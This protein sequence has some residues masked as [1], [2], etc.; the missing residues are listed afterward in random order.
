MTRTPPSPPEVVA[1][2]AAADPPDEA[3]LTAVASLPAMGPF[4]LLALFRG[5]GAKGAWRQVTSGRLPAVPALEGRLG[6]DPAALVRRW[7]HAAGRLDVAELWAAHLAAGVRTAALGSPQYPAALAEDPEPPAVVFMRGDP[8]VLD[9]RRVAVVGTRNCTRVG[10]E[11]AA[12][13]GHGLAAV[14]VRVV[15]GL[16]LGVDGAAHTGALEAALEHPCA[17]PP[18]AVVAGGLDVVYPRR[19]ADLYRRVEQA[20]LVV[21]EAPLGTAPEPWRFPARNR[22]IA[23]L[24]EAVVVVESRLR[25]GSMHTADEALARGI[26]LLAVPGSIRS[27]ASAG[28]N[29]LLA[30]GAM[31]ACDVDD[32]LTAVGLGGVRR[33]TPA[34]SAAWSTRSPA[35]PNDPVEQAVLEALGWEPLTF[36]QLVFR[37]GLGLA[38]LAERVASLESQGFL[39][40][41]DGWLER[42]EGRRV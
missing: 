6:R 16:A 7:A 22:V 4:R 37:T 13:F 35:R 27:P 25:G 1:H 24:A 18:I 32:L 14:G 38:S 42:S 30:A 21:S 19:H 36:E 28:T 29:A 5:F 3:Y 17:G 34:R 40:R 11:V 39:V 8:A 26:T 41:S 9:G 33:A 23:G 12:D 2:R 10:R 20:G 15:S 31:V